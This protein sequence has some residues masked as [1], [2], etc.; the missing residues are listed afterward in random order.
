MTAYWRRPMTPADM[1]GVEAW[2]ITE[3]MDGAVQRWRV[4]LSAGWCFEAMVERIDA[5][6]GQHFVT[7]A[8]LIAARVLAGAPP[9]IPRAMSASREPRPAPSASPPASSP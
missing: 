1:L 8:G 6:P 4:E 5:T 2:R 9:V 3:S 7:L